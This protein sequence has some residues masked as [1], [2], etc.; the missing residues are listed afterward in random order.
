M[1]D[2]G[3]TVLGYILPNNRQGLEYALER[4]TLEHFQD[5]IQRTFWKVLS[6]YGER[7]ADVFAVE[8]LTSLLTKAKVDPGK[9]VL[10]AEYYNQYAAREVNESSFHYAVDALND[11]LNKHQTGEAFVTAY[12]ILEEGDE[13]DGEFLTGHEA[14]REYFMS[15]IS[16][17]EERSVQEETPEGDIRKE[18]DRI[19]SLYGEAEERGEPDGIKF[20]IKALDE[21]T[22]GLQRGELGIA[23]A[24]TNE[25]K[26]QFATQLSWSAC[27]EQGK[28]V[29]FATSETIRDTTMRRILAR[30]SRLPQFG[31]PRGLNSKDIQFGR[32]TPD[33][34][35][36]YFDVVKDFTTNS[37]YATLNISQMP[38]NA[39]VGLIDR[40]ATRVHRSNPLDL[41]VIDYLQLL[42]AENLRLD[43]RQAYNEILRQ[44]KVLA[45]SFGG[46]RGISI[47]SPWQ[48]KQSDYKA[49]LTTMNYT[50][51]SLADTS[52]ADKSPDLIITL[53]RPTPTSQEGSTQILKNRD[54]PV[55]APSPIYL[56]YRSTYIGDTPSGHSELEDSFGLGLAGLLA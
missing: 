11:D 2:L 20:G 7:Y 27:V 23:A 28:N 54:G 44:T 53:L 13:I 43:E 30:H 36:V 41:L 14:A 55:M 51:G 37:N 16:V 34:K 42:K 17:I 25:G 8:H 4:L 10:Y 49:A 56:D 29:F 45:P 5:G 50:L 18:G 35:A 52:E 9:V 3:A 21:A 12:K 22:G 46:G 48:I 19:L 39:T 6:S 47:L 15:R 24:Y 33:E 38:R 32:L 31:L 40:R 1:S 26:S